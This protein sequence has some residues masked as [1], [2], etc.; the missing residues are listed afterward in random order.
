[1]DNIREKGHTEEEFTR[2]IIQFEE[3]IAEEKKIIIEAKK[4]I[5]I[6]N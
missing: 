5:Q 6:R 3:D 4:I 2:K 1:M